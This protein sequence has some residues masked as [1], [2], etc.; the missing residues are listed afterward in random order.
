MK[1][2]DRTATP[3]F[4]WRNAPE[5]AAVKILTVSD[6]AA[7]VIFRMPDGT[8]RAE[9]L[10][11]PIDGLAS[12]SAAMEAAESLARQWRRGRG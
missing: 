3:E 5:P 1:I 7:V 10:L 9:M 4:S 12:L 11:K 8:W 2:E 6:S